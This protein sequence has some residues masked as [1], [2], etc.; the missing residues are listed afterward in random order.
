M[1]RPGSRAALYAF[2]VARAKAARHKAITPDRTS[3]RPAI[4]P[5]ETQVDGAHGETV[6]ANVDETAERK[7]RVSEAAHLVAN[8][9]AELN[10][11]LAQ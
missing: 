3:G 1:V 4:G 7:R 5:R 11:R 2:Q 8:R 6:A 10:E 9:S